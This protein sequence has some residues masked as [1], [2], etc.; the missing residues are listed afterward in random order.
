MK[1]NLF[2]DDTMYFCSNMN[3][4]H[5]AKLLQNQDRSVQTEKLLQDWK[6]YINPSK[7]VTV[8]F[9]NKL[10]VG[11]RPFRVHGQD[12]T[13]NNSVKYLGVRLDSKLKFANHNIKWKTFVAVVRNVY[14]T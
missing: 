2:A 4:H 12:V 3:K 8:L 10:P 11:M 13:W 5:T 14:C 9:G 7:T 6:M 1:I